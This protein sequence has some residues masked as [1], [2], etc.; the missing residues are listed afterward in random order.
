MAGREE[1]AA[2]LFEM[3]RARGPIDKARAAARAWR[4][5]REL[6]PSERR[7]IA[8]EIGSSGA[9]ELLESLGRGGRGFSPAAVL[10]ALTRVGDDD[11]T[12]LDE[13]VAD[14]R[15]PERRV[16]AFVDVLDV[17]AEAAIG[18]AAP[19]E[20][21]PTDAEPETVLPP[22]PVVEGKPLSGASLD[23]D[24]A[25]DDTQAVAAEVTDEGSEVVTV[26]RPGPPPPAV[27]QP[28]P[29]APRTL[30]AWDELFRRPPEVPG[31]AVESTVERSKPA[32]GATSGVGERPASVLRR[33]RRLRAR[34]VELVTASVDQ[35]R[36]ALDAF[37]EPWARRR[38]L[39]FLL[40]EGIPADIGDAIDLVADLER[41][42]DRRWCLGVLAE[43]GDLAG[44]ELGRALDLLASPSAR[45]WLAR[46][47]ELDTHR[48]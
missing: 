29:P 11:R 13:I 15:D 33:L 40:A 7:M 24:D 48:A 8:R 46:R 22:V 34:R 39:C 14:L 43:R 1:L 16:E 17:A 28:R 38:A 9:D 32:V 18:E 41:P 31:P 5:L 10:E 21:D 12:S 2:L 19:R 45:R 6:S 36:D 20:E 47:A 23:S 42:V 27:P 25:V 35:V 3:Q 44:D 30:S 26:A 4:T 37:P